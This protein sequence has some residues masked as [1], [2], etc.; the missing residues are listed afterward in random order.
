[1]QTFL[2]QRALMGGMEKIVNKDVL[3]TVNAILSVIT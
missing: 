3:G 2:Q 1:M